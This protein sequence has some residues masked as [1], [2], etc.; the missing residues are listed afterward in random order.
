M[1]IT[2]M[3]I[4]DLDKLQQ[5]RL[6]RLSHFFASSL[7]HCKIEVENSSRLII[8][9][10]NSKIMDELTDE[11]DDLSHYVWLILGIRIVVLH[12]MVQAQPSTAPDCLS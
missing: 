3:N 5:L 4:N 1:S 2:G 11:L 9:C 12:M 8:Y 6:L 7:P 10:P